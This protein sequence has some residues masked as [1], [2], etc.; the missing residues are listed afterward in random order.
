MRSTK[1][2]SIERDH[3]RARQCDS[4]ASRRSRSYFDEHEAWRSR[5]GWPRPFAKNNNTIWSENME[6]RRDAF[7]DVLTSSLFPAPVYNNYGGLI[8][9]EK[10]QSPEF[11]FRSPDLG[12]IELNTDHGSPRLYCRHSLSQVGK[13]PTTDSRNFGEQSICTKC[14][15]RVSKMADARHLLAFASN[16]AYHRLNPANTKYPI[17]AD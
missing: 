16:T 15:M 7:L 11:K 1:S 3:F 13:L 10:F 2:G 14:Y 12:A 8:A 5:A 17:T 6:S 4:N 9:T